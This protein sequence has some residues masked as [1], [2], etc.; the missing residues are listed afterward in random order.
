MAY[1]AQYN[2]NSDEFIPLLP[3]HVYVLID[4]RDETIFYVGKGK[5]ERALN[6]V[7]E[8]KQLTAKGNT[9][10][11]AKHRRIRDILGRCQP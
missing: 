5:G 10:E 3:Y 9:L 7:T 11:S 6:H 1:D 8:V 2:G 4:P